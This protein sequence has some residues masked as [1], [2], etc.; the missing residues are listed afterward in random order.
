MLVD[1]TDHT[2]RVDD[3]DTEG[4]IVFIRNPAKVT[5]C[6]GYMDN[7]EL[8]DEKFVPNPTARGRCSRRATSGCGLAAIQTSRPAGAATVWSVTATRARG[9]FDSPETGTGDNGVLLS[10]DARLQQG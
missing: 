3:L 8:T 7:Q 6:M 4:E 10:L 5:I 2:I 1:P 9:T